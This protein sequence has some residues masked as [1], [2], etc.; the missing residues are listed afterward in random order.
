MVGTKVLRLKKRIVHFS[1]RAFFSVVASSM[2]LLQ[3]CLPEKGKASLVPSMPVER[4]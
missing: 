2:A 3:V 1:N 4:S